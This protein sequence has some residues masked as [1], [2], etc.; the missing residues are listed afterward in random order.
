MAS[1]AS[2]ICTDPLQISFHPPLG[3]TEVLWFG[4]EAYNRD[5]ASCGTPFQALGALSELRE[6]GDP[7]A[8]AEGKVDDVSLPTM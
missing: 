3:A 7:Y 6:L 4:I 8:T 5:R 1:V 2:S